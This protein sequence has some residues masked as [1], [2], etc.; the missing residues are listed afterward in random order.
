MIFICDRSSVIYVV[1]I[2]KS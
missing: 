1:N 2:N